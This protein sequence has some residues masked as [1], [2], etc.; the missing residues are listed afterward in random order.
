MNPEV[1]FE[2]LASEFIADPEGASAEYGAEFVKGIDAYLDP[3]GVYD[4]VIQGRTMLAP[5]EDVQ[6]VAAC[7]PAFAKGGDQFSF[8][9]GHKVGRGD[10]ARFVIDLLKAWRG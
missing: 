3:V 7:D 6:Y 10:D 4:C 5:S 8:A 1:T 9:I 2:S